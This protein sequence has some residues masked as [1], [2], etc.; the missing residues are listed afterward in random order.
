MRK[1]IIK[2]IISKPNVPFG[3]TVQ[4]TA[5]ERNEF[6]DVMEQAG[7]GWQMLY[8]RMTYRGFDAWE[9]SGIDRCMSD[10]W[11]M[12]HSES[13]ASESDASDGN[14][15]DGDT[16]T[17]MPPLDHFW[18]TLVEQGHNVGF[19]KYMEVHGMS[20]NTTIK[21]FTELNFKPWEMDGVASII[22]RIDD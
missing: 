20:R 18:Q 2:E 6:R 14:T 3:R 7:A 5:E 13:N 1:E 4:M 10:F 15:S 11:Q 17:P 8:Q 19:I 22:Q 16:A 21:R 9:L 12:V